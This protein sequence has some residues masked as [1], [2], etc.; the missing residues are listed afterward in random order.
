[1]I[2]SL[3]VLYWFLTQDLFGKIEREAKNDKLCAINS[4]ALNKFGCRWLRQPWFECVTFI[5][6]DFIIIW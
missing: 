3:H 4:L 6:I 2:S 5:M 1:M